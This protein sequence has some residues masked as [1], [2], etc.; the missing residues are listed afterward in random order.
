MAFNNL[1][2]AAQRLE[3]GN[4]TARTAH[5][6][7]SNTDSSC[8]DW[9]QTFLWR[10]YVTALER[11]EETRNQDDVRL[12]YAAWLAFNWAYL[13]EVERLPGITVPKRLRAL[14]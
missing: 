4:V 2:Q 11:A 7:A 10:A 14:L 8:D 9:L 6:I 12:A 5:E 13:T 3:F 1:A